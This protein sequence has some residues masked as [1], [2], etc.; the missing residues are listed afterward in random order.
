[1]KR[2]S[3]LLSLLLAVV[4]Y[5]LAIPS[6]AAPIKTE[7][8]ITWRATTI[9]P[10]WYI[11][12]ALPN[13]NTPIEAQLLLTKNGAILN[14]ANYSMRWFVNG[15]L[16]DSGRGLAFINIDP[17]QTFESTLRLRVSVTEDD[18]SVA[19]E[20]SIS[21]N[22]IKPKVIIDTPTPYKKVSKNPVTLTALSFFF[23]LTDMQNIVTNWLVDGIFV[24]NEN[25]LTVAATATTLPT[26]R[27]E[28]V[29]SNTVSGIESAE[30]S[31]TLFPTL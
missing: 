26:A 14:P 22:R 18:G 31:I 20:Q 27:I 30:K 29:V 8:D 15:R 1:M 24:S 3:A 7:A 16:V 11:G 21:I 19:A 6:R 2:L 4:S 9:V 17:G 13:Q 12:K 25:N 5:G 10:G 23:S 28:A